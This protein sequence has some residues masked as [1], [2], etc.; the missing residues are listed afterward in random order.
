MTA[1]R[2]TRS[3]SVLDT[4]V[5]DQLA[6]QLS[7]FESLD[8]K[9]GVLL[10]FAGL[11]VALAPGSDSTWIDVARF[12]G[13][14]SAVLALLAFLPRNY[15]VLDLLRLRQRYLSAEP[16]FTRLTLL[17]THIQMLEQ[18]RR[19]IEQKASRLKIAIGALLLAIAL[20]FIG[21][22][23][24][25]DSGGANERRTTDTRPSSGATQQP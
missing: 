3:L 11:F 7:H 4:E 15:P 23:V 5:R 21:L 19:L 20:A 24:E 1:S 8:A 10:G 25:S 2:G 14:V 9:A 22:L 6:S 18:A 17:D 12:A 16:D 13:V